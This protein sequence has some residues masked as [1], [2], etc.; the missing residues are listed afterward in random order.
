[1]VVCR[2]TVLFWLALAWT[3]SPVAARPQTDA[4]ADEI[5]IERCDILPVVKLRIDSTDMRFLLD[6]GGTTVLNIKT[7][8]SGRSKQIQITSWSGTAA[9]SAREVF[10]PELVLGRHHLRNVKLPTM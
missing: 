8:A 6:T 5:P 4:F 2:V 3:L 10:L 1:M 7:F 9:T